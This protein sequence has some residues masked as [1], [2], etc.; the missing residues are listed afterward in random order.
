MVINSLVRAAWLYSARSPVQR[1][2]DGSKDVAV[3]LHTLP[4]CRNPK[5]QVVIAAQLPCDWGEV[6][7]LPE[8]SKDGWSDRK[9]SILGH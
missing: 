9:A 3:G 5:K 1:C 4:A 6:K 2:Q 7:Y 8:L